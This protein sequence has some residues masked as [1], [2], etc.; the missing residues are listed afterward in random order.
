MSNL[1]SYV[2]KRKRLD[3]LSSQGAFLLATAGCLLPTSLRQAREK[4]GMTQ[5]HCS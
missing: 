4:A 3:P 2:K 5:D 1:E